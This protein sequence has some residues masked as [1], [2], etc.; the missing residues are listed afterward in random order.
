M[1]DEIIGNIMELIVPF[2]CMDNPDITPSYTVVEEIIK[3]SRTACALSCVSR[4]FRYIALHTPVLWSMVVKKQSFPYKLFVERSG[5]VPLRVACDIDNEDC[6]VSDIRDRLRALKIYQP[7]FDR[8]H[9]SSGNYTDMNFPVLETL[10]VTGNERFPY[11]FLLRWQA[12]VLKHLTARCFILPIFMASTLTTLSLDLYFN[13][14]ITQAINS[15]RGLFQHH[16]TT[17]LTQCKMLKTLHLKWRKGLPADFGWRGAT[18]PSLES[19]QIS[20]SDTYQTSMGAFWKG[21]Q[22]PNLRQL[23]IT[24]LFDRTDPDASLEDLFDSLGPLA[25]VRILDLNVTWHARSREWGCMKPFDVPFKYIEQ[26]MPNIAD[27]KLDG[28]GAH[29]QQ[30]PDCQLPA[31]RTLRAKFARYIFMDD[32]LKFVKS[33]IVN[34]EDGGKIDPFRLFA[35]VRPR[36]SVNTVDYKEA[37]AN[38]LLEYIDSNI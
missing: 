17:F 26:H 33:N 24:G 9:R 29:S 38:G 16:L 28:V 35:S 5:R 25:S 2:S 13:P 12:P 19:L 10:I 6:Q 27:I 32:I 11:G 14:Q 34:H 22:M 31:F 7:A 36:E 37:V 3:Y 23:I 20:L 21:I 30:L 18:L 1:P 8:F 4:R 15:R